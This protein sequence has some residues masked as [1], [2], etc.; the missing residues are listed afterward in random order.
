MQASLAPA[1]GQRAECLC[2]HERDHHH[3]DRQ[4]Q[5]VYGSIFYHFDRQTDVYLQPTTS[6]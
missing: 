4:T 6:R 5:D 1:H 2:R 3:R